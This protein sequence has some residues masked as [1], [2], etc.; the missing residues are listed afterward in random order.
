[1]EN[2]PK[3][4]NNPPTLKEVNY[5]D[6][7]PISKKLLE[8]IQPALFGENAPDYSNTGE[9]VI[10]FLSPA[11]PKPEKATDIIAWLE[12]QLR[13]NNKVNIIEI[14]EIINELNANTMDPVIEIVKDHEADAEVDAEADAEAEADQ[15]QVPNQNPEMEP[16]EEPEAKE[17][18]QTKPQPQP[19]PN[20]ENKE[21]KDNKKNTD[22]KGNPKNKDNKDHKDE[23]VKIH[24]KTV[25]TG[26]GAVA[27]DTQGG[28]AVLADN[29]ILDLIGTDL[30]TAI[31]TTNGEI[32]R[33]D[34]IKELNID[35]VA[36]NADGSVTIA[37]Q[38][39]LPSY[40]P[41]TPNNQHSSLPRP[42]PKPRDA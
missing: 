29:A 15:N 5:T 28:N 25:I 13:D 42:E 22:N 11:S 19:Q 32:K 6:L 34:V 39:H 16:E 40:E 26:Q 12:E 18:K 14:L 35:S 31:P 21:N 23:R 7:D 27:V 3:W 10:S 33:L 36:V 1:M 24:I 9:P 20:P 30:W 8:T 17:T 37:V 38:C 4:V 2:R 41:L